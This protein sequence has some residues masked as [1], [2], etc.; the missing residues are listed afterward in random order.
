[1]KMLF[2][3]LI[4]AV[5]ASISYLSFAGEEEKSVSPLYEIDSK[6]ITECNRAI[7]IAY[8]SVD[9][10]GEYTDRAPKCCGQCTTQYN[11]NG[12][13]ITDGQGNRHCKACQ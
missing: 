11:E 5:F 3:V 4:L 6:L 8:I 7:D 13:W 2:K 12:C 10:S 1:M 9:D